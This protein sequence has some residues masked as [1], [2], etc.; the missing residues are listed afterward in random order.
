M[1]D[2]SV[3]KNRNYA[4]FVD[5]ERLAG[6][7]DIYPGSFLQIDGSSDYQKNSTEAASGR[8]LMADLS[9]SGADVA[10]DESYTNGD[11]VSAVRVPVG[12]QVEGRLAAGGD[13]TTA[14]NAN[15]SEDELLVETNVGALASHTSADTSGDPE[16][17]VYR[18][19]EAVDNS[20][21][22]AGVSNQVY[23]EVVRVA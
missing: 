12:G 19:L 15:V 5:E 3:V 18:A 13:L 9:R 23:I 20:G 10:K 11:E 21:A 17:A 2:N 22:S 7:A 4:P 1:A 8:G 6:E 16:G 14:S